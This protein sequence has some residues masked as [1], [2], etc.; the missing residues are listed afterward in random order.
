MRGFFIGRF[1]PLHLGHISIIETALEEVDQLVVGVGSAEKSM[2]P[3]DPFSA[4]ERMDMILAVSEGGGLR[5]R[6][7]PVPIRDI[8]RYSIWVDH[9]ISLCPSFEVVY[10]NNPLTRILFEKNGLKVRSTPLID[11]SELSGAEIRKRMVDG[12][13]WR[14]LVPAEVAELMDSIGAEARMREIRGLGDKP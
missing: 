8:N 7:I 9:V 13:D 6:V 10:S 14:T 11:R 4:G 12:S 2:L 1:Q 5:G 3:D